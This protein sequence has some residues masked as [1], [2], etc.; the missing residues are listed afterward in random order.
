[1]IIGV[2]GKARSGK[3]VFSD[4]AVKAFGAQKVSF[5]GPLKLEVTEFLLDSGIGFRLENL[6][7][8]T[9]DKEEILKT[10]H[11]NV[12]LIQHPYYP[13]FLKFLLHYGS[14][15]GTTWSFTPRALMQWWGT[16][17]RRNYFGENYWI[18]RF[19]EAC[20][21]PK[22]LYV[23]D[24]CRF[25]NEAQAIKEAGGKLVRIERP[26]RPIGSNPE[27][28][29]EVALDGWTAWDMVI[30]NVDPLW[31]FQDRCQRVI[32]GFVNQ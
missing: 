16:E 14:C 21:N 30:Q 10:D 24:D 15:V 17:F 25:P 12:L 20:D 11:H 27:H 3:G 31:I 4:I 23:V 26:V 13:Y 29:S 7:G 2:S 22:Q 32:N 9:A 19:L 18:S 8:D 28:P 6:T 1:M 5:A